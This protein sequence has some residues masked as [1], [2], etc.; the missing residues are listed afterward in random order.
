MPFTYIRPTEEWGPQYFWRRH[1]WPSLDTPLTSSFFE[2]NSESLPSMCEN[3]STE[4][5]YVSTG[6]VDCGESPRSS[7]ETTSVLT[8]CVQL[9]IVSVDAAGQQSFTAYCQH[10]LCDNRLSQNTFKRNLI[11]NLFPRWR[12]QFT[13]AGHAFLDFDAVY[14][15]SWDRIYNRFIVHLS[16]YNKPI[17][18]KCTLSWVN[19]RRRWEWDL[20]PQS[21]QFTQLHSAVPTSLNSIVPD[22]DCRPTRLPEIRTG[23]TDPVFR[24]VV[25]M[26]YRER[27]KNPKY[28]SPLLVRGSVKQCT[29]RSMYCMHRLLV[30]RSTVSG[31]TQTPSPSNARWFNIQQIEYSINRMN[32]KNQT[33][34]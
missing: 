5:F 23:R 9:P 29:E 33:I 19:V 16:Q 25:L 14:V 32:N 34:N 17:Q 18:F 10:V 31:Y 12:I 20:C 3:I 4:L 26:W 1:A 7:T 30:K 8:V 6:A 27:Y 28:F 13:A 2:Y 24:R 11:T 21:K 22:I 15:E